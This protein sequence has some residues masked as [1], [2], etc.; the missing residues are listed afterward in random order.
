M[1]DAHV[2]QTLHDLL[3]CDTED[4]AGDPFM[5]RIRHVATLVNCP[6]QPPPDAWSF[7]GD[8]FV[9]LTFSPTKVSASVAKLLSAT[10]RAMMGPMGIGDLGEYLYSSVWQMKWESSDTAEFLKALA[11][12]RRSWCLPSSASLR[13]AERVWAEQPV[14]CPRLM[15]LMCSMDWYRVVNLM[16]A[17]FVANGWPRSAEAVTYVQ[18]HRWDKFARTRDS[19]VLRRVWVHAV[20]TQSVAVN[21]LVPN[22]HRL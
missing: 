8:L 17:T 18:R 16:D 1:D 22:L 4:D 7:I 5:A 10:W 2:K 9:D 19:K 12:A 6:G 15:Q 21:P 13:I 14:N 3:E 11:L 20:V